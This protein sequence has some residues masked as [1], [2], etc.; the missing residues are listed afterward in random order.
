MKLDNPAARLLSILEEGLTKSPNGNCR[1]TWAGL[2]RVDPKNKALLMGKLGKVMALS[3]DIIECLNNI[4]NIKVERYLDWAEP[5]DTAFSKNNLNENWKGFIVHINKR[6]INCLSMTSDFL[7]HKMPEPILS[8][9]NLDNILSNARKLIDEVK[10]SDLP[11]KVKEYMVKQLH[12]VCLSVEEYQIT[13]AESISEVI[14]ST[15]GHG[16]L[17]NESVVVTEKNSTA[18]KFWQYMAHISIILSF[19]GCVLQLSPIVTKMLPDISFEKE[20]DA[21][22]K[23]EQ[24]DEL[25][26]E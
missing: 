13:G 8:A 20:S 24:E 14:E 10:G 25:V 26:E 9:S 11:E 16:V 19:A 23:S 7:S 4:D 17:H 15:F 6:V 2:L 1:S 21:I 18:K 5:L 3:T 12:K 22:N